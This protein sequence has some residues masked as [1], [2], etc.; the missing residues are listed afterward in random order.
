MKQNKIVKNNRFV[1]QHKHSRSEG[2]G[3]EWVSDGDL[4]H[5]VRVMSRVTVIDTFRWSVINYNRDMLNWRRITIRP[6]N[7]GPCPGRERARRTHT[8]LSELLIS[9]ICI[10][11]LTLS[12]SS[13]SSSHVNGKLC[14]YN[15]ASQISYFNIN[16]SYF[17]SQ[18]SSHFSDN[19]LTNLKQAGS[20]AGIP[21]F[22]A[23]S[24]TNSI[25]SCQSSVL[26]WPQPSLFSLV[27]W[28]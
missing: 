24:Q 28:H 8:Q 10:H 15:P 14:W 4:S 6:R 2:I 27:S 25:S 3:C 22:P 17:C 12:M 20:P 26:A 21:S 9:V 11:H 19:I 23:A 13:L 7:R 16:E 18:L 1:W 5:I